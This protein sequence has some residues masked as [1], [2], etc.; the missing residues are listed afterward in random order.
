[1]NKLLFAITVIGTSLLFFACN[2]D[3][4]E[5]D[6]SEEKPLEEFNYLAG[7]F[8]DI[9]MLRFRIPGFDD[10][11]LQQK[12]LSYYLYEAGLSGR[13]IFFDQNGLYSG[14]FIFKVDIFYPWFCQNRRFNSFSE[15]IFHQSSSAIIC[16]E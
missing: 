4:K 7:K 9:Q 10:L 13:D 3:Q 16:Q 1:M 6:N 2:S 14:F 5:L 11:P 15:W 12:I 8:A